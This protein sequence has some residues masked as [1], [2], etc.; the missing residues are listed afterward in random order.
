ML[1]NFTLPKGSSDAGA[2]FNVRYMSAAVST[3]GLL[4]DVYV[5]FAE[6]VVSGVLLKRFR[7]LGA[8]VQTMIGFDGNTKNDQ[9][10]ACLA[11]MWGLEG[12]T[13]V[14]YERGECEPTLK[15]LADAKHAQAQQQQTQR[16]F[17]E[18]TSA[19]LKASLNDIKTD[20]DDVKGGMLQVVGDVGEVKGSV[21]VMCSTLRVV[22]DKVDTRATLEQENTELKGVAARK[23][24]LARQAAGKQSVITKEKNQWQR[25]YDTQKHINRYQMKNRA[26]MASKIAA[27]VQDKLDLTA[28]VLASIEREKLAAEREK[29]L[30]ADIKRLSNNTAAAT[31]GAAAS[32]ATPSTESP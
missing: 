29:D 18:K 1:R 5:D 14:L 3:E 19:G 23:T 8:Y 15:S 26:D 10:S 2:V 25:M 22:A 12:A 9:A 30:R 11:R 6:R 4:S 13:T 28:M 20:I 17:D 32:P 16:E 24:F 27:L 31:A 7:E 21:D